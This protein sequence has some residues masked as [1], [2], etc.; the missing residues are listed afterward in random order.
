MWAGHK[1]PALRAHGDLMDAK[2]YAERIAAR[3]DAFDAFPAKTAGRRAIVRMLRE[4]PPPPVKHVLEAAFLKSRVVFR[5][6]EA[7]LRTVALALFSHEELSAVDVKLLLGVRPVD[8][9]VPFV[10]R[11][12]TTWRRRLRLLLGRALVFLKKIPAHINKE[13]SAP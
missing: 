6:Y 12:R 3:V 4:E 7:E 10:L 8:T 1:A 13:F 9:V 5:A 11:K 2:R